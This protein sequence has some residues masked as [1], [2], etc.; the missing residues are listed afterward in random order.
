M[1]TTKK[2]LSSLFLCLTILAA[3]TTF[4]NHT[5]VAQAAGDVTP[6]TTEYEVE[7]YQTGIFLGN[8][9]GVNVSGGEAVYLTYTVSEVA[10]DTTTQSGLVA[11]T[12]REEAY[13]YLKGVM[14][15]NNLKS[16]LMR[17]GYTYFIKF[18]VTEFGFEYVAVYSN[19]SDENYETG[20][21][22]TTGEVVDNMQYCG[23]WLSGGDLTAKLTHVRC[24]DK[25]GNDL[26]VAVQGGMVL[27]PTF[28]PN[29]NVQ[30]SYE[31]TLDNAHAIA[32]SNER[33]SKAK[34]IFMEYE[35][36]D[37]T[38]TLEQTGFI[39]SNSPTAMYPYDGNQGFMMFQNI[40]DGSGGELAIPG[41]KYLLRFTRTD[42]GYEVRAR[43][44]LNGSNHYVLFPNTIGT[45]N[46][47][48]GYAS[49][50]LG[51]GDLTATFFNVKCYDGEGK[52]LGI[53][54][55]Q[56]DVEI[57][58]YGG[59][60]DYSVCSAMY[61][62]KDNDTVITLN[63]DCSATVQKAGEKNA[64]NGTYKI[65]GLTLTMEA[66]GK[67]SNY[68]YSYIQMTDESNH[69]YVRLKE[70]AVKF[71]T[72]TEDI[73]ETASKE[74]GYQIKMPE[75]PTMKGNT[76]KGWYLG[77]GKEYTNPSITT[78]SQTVYAKWVDGDGNEYL[79]TSAGIEAV[80]ADRTPLI[81]GILC[82][83]IV[84]ATAAGIIL[85]IK[86]GAKDEANK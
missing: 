82:L 46:P 69:T 2:R 83:L 24:Y 8:E 81:I 77:N 9:K 60:E 55:N 75:N 18:E 50:W 52:N 72:G 56:E 41:A 62:C 38:N 27:D 45:Y 6:S 7:L 12:D 10:E 31:F 86:K 37:V 11:T 19:G 71:V 47:K 59:W 1:N 76:F 23:I 32:I 49:I 85:V 65:D 25:K 16:L 74:N 80:K 33:Y 73:V 40:H 68:E 15:F 13:P 63:E 70:Y 44:T 22:H 39:M 51:S 30:H 84:L 78:K 17:P 26:G 28:T 66:G 53:Q 61:Y 14:Q 42:D 21:I 64:Q 36:K 58:H 67:S 79:A 54:T 48:Y 35:V 43:Y 29:P 5:L 3:T 34:D 4:Y 57:I 20:F